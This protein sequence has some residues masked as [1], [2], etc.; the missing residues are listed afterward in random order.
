MV[1]SIVYIKNVPDWERWVRVLMG[2]VLLGAALAIFGYG[3]LG[4]GTGVFG[5]IV[6]MTGIVGFCPACALA[7]RKLDQRGRS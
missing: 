6:M 4:F 3:W 5:F 2:I 7:G 1:S